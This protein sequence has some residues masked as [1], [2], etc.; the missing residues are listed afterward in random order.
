MKIYLKYNKDALVLYK[1]HELANCKI[2]Y[3]NIL[4][5]KTIEI[6]MRNELFQLIKDDKR[7]EGFDMFE[8]FSLIRELSGKTY[9]EQIKERR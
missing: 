9:L 3:H 7:F 5:M 2:E 1:L 8:N 6:K 4:S